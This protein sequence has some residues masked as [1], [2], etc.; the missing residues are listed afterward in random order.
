MRQR[1]YKYVIL[2]LT[3]NRSEDKMILKRSDKKKVKGFAL[4]IDLKKV[5]SVFPNVDCNAATPRIVFFRSPSKRTVASDT[6]TA[7]SRAKTSRI[8]FTTTVFSSLLFAFWISNKRV[9][10]FAFFL[11]Y[12]FAHMKLAVCPSHHPSKFRG[13]TG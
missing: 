6:A 9:I 7:V 1:S 4:Q 8:L 10:F 12:C 11:C 13:Y 3:N 5:T 2:H